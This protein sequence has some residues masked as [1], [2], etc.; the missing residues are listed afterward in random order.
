MSRYLYS[1]TFILLVPLLCNPLGLFGQS[2]AQITNV[3]FYVRNDTLFISYDLVKAKPNE[4]FDVTLTVKTPS[5]KVFFPVALSG[6]AGKFVAG[7]KGKQIIWAIAKD[8]VFIDEE[9]FVELRATPMGSQ[10]QTEVQQQTPPQTKQQTPPVVTKEPEYSSTQS[11][12]IVN[13]TY[14]KGGAIVLSAIMPGLGVTKQREGGAQW[15]LGLAAYGAVAGGVV[16]N[17]MATSAY[18][19][20]KDATTAGERDDLFQKAT[21]RA[22]TGKILYYAAAGIWAGS[23][24]WTILTPNNVKTKFSFYGTYDPIVNKPMIGLTIKL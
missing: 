2:K 13:R 17:V 7:G 19:Q 8:N 18:N 4:W 3:D 6:H 9:I 5:G 24:I 1:L 12:E 10:P 23:M 15:L 20:Y 16:L 21:S 11:R 14:S 22:Q